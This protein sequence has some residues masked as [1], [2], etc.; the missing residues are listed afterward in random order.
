MVQKTT[1]MITGYADISERT[2]SENLHTI[3]ADQ[4]RMKRTFSQADFLGPNQTT[5]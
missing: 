1:K 2:G 3:L 4:A 5:V